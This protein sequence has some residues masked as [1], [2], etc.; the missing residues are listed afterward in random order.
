MGMWTISYFA[1][2]TT[3]EDKKVVVT[4][5]SWKYNP[6]MNIWQYIDEKGNVVKDKTIYIDGEE[7]V[8]GKD[9]ALL[10]KDS[11]LQILSNA[12]S[13]S[14]GKVTIDN[15]ES[16]KNEQNEEKKSILESELVSETGVS[17]GFENNAGR[18]NFFTYDQKGNK[19]FL[20]KYWI[21]VKNG[22]EDYYY[23]MDDMGNMVV[24]FSNID[25]SVYYFFEDGINKGQ[26]AKG[27]VYIK[28]ESFWFDENGKYIDDL[29]RIKS[30]NKIPFINSMKNIIYNIVK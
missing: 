23:A 14:N 10:G 18:Y 12:I 20:K 13:I 19:R 5:G 29:T 27:V 6:Q 17:G 8:F 24:G 22:K 28:D 3:E 15:S 11:F 7:Y 25:G 2:A 1:S 26:M 16:N 21:N 9:G 30:L 4:S